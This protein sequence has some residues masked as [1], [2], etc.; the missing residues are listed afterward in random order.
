MIKEKGFTIVELMV[1]LAVSLIIILAMTTLFKNTSRQVYGKGTDATEGVRGLIPSARQDSQ[2]ATSILT[3]QNKLQSA[4]FGISSAELD[5]NIL[6]ITGA[7]LSGTTLSGTNTTL[8]PSGVSG[9]AIL[10]ESNLDYPTDSRTCHGILSDSTTRAVYLLE[11]ISPTPCDSLKTNW[12]TSTI[13]WST[14]TLIEA[15]LLLSA[16]TLTT[17]PGAGCSPYGSVATATAGLLITLGYAN[18]S[19]NTANTT[20]LCL[21]NFVSGT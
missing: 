17:E 13:V 19:T 2:L 20:S 3:I 10:W 8:S 5:T 14:K 18:S 7:A 21:T 12:N 1:G 15:N 6:L 9:N 4:G 16:I 11:A